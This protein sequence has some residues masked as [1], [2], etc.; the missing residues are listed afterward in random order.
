[1]NSQTN[2][3]KNNT[4]LD[5]AEADALLEEKQKQGTSGLSW[6]EIAK[7]DKKGWHE[8]TEMGEGD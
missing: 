7:D 6:D 5:D 8:I 2:S 4:K 1:M 3:D